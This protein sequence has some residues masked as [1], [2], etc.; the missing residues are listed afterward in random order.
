MEAVGSRKSVIA[1]AAITDVGRSRIHLAARRRFV[2][3]LMLLSSAATIC[4][5]AAWAAPITPIQS[6]GGLGPL[7]LA[8]G[9][10]SFNTDPADPLSGTYAINGV[11]QPGTATIVTLPPATNY[12]PGNGTGPVPSF[13]AYVWNFSSINLGSGVTVVDDGPLALILASS[14]SATVNASFPF[15]GAAGSN[16]GPGLGGGGGA[17][18]GSLSI[19]AATGLAFGGSVDV[20]G[21]AGGTSG[22]SSGTS[23]AGAAAAGGGSGGAGGDRSAGGAGGAGADGPTVGLNLTI[24][25]IGLHLPL[26]TTLA[27]GGGGGGGS[28]IGGP[29]PASD[30]GFPGAPGGAFNPCVP[31]PG[32]TGG[33]GTGA[34]YD[35]AFRPGG[36]G[37]PS[38]IGGGAG[39]TKTGGG[40][41]GGGSA[42]NGGPGG[43]G[44]PGGLLS[45]GGGGGGGGDLCTAL[46]PAGTVLSNQGGGGS[47]GGA[48]S[49]GSVIAPPAPPA[50]RV[51][52]GGGG[53]GG[54]VWLGTDTGLLDLT[55]ATIDVDGGASNGGAGGLGLLTLIA[56]SSVDGPSGV[57]FVYESSLPLEDYLPVGGAG[58]GGAGASGLTVSEPA[59]VGLFALAC[60][61]LLTVRR[62]PA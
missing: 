17:G 18:G 62:K 30:G 20:S 53:G 11:T 38:G 27:G 8:S 1:Y 49:P 58:G 13:S 54:G 2:Y 52:M 41:G 56:S 34:G 51:A 19:F 35:A 36:F 12:G 32:G 59:E 28:Y 22:M 31:T 15:A 44:G 23:A 39:G 29:G 60:S 57:N 21:G 4:S 5:T 45:G 24:R 10:L 47:G 6:D 55:G 43:P 42:A 3:R 14:G 50:R 7:S 46:M 37:G 40:G 61:M 26:T 9:I 16:G 48:G 25:G 33:P